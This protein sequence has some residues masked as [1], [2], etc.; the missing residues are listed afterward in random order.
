[1]L[2]R[3]GIIL[4]F[5]AALALASCRDSGNDAEHFR[6]AGKLF[7][8]NYRVATATYLVN[9]VPVQPPGE[10]ETAVAS[11][12]DPAGGP[13]IVV[14]QKIWPRLDKTTIES[15]PLHCVVKDRPY[16]V[17]IRIEG[18]DGTVLQTI[19]T[20]MTSTEDQMI[21]PDRPLVVGPVY[22]PNPELAGHPDG[23]LPSFD[24]PRCPAKS[25][26]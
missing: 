15:P 4:L 8:F 16:A 2:E 26:G 12:E 11:F 18:P 25:Q 17:S 19:E 10:G 6:I 3:T 1:M 14:R 22:T 21:L 13:P 9:L 20:T 7:V 24:A 23:K 5:V